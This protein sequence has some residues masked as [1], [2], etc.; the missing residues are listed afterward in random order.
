[1]NS[2][3]LNKRVMAIVQAAI[4]PIVTEYMQ[5]HPEYFH[6]CESGNRF[7]CNHNITLSFQPETLRDVADVKPTVFIELGNPDRG[8]KLICFD[9]NPEELMSVFCVD[10]KWVTQ[11]VSNG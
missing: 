2:N 4:E 3:E 1:M 9:H 6:L 8:H 7:I 11:E 10:S 5:Q